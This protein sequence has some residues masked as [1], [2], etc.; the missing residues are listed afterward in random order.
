MKFTSLLSA[1]IVNS[2]ITK[3]TDEKRV[4]VLIIDDTIF[5]RNCSK[6]V[7]LLTKVYN[8]AKKKYIKGFRFLTLG[9]SDENT[10]LPVNSCLLSSENEK[11]RINESKELDKR[12]VG[13]SKRSLSC[14]NA[15]IAMLSLIGY[16]I[17]TCIPAT[18]IFYE[19]FI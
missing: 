3:L 15:T 18:H 13:F 6:K 1:K 4:N 2:T 11:S 14:K 8:H 10:F 17:K 19:Y 5:E 16:A 12:S 7:E 9:W